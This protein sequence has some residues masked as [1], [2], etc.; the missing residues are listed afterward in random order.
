M[1]SSDPFD[2]ARLAEDYAAYRADKDAEK[3]LAR[4]RDAPTPPPKLFLSLLDYRQP[5]CLR[6]RSG[7]FELWLRATPKPKGGLL[8]CGN[9]DDELPVLYW[10]LRDQAA[11]I[12]Q[13]LVGTH[14]K[15]IEEFVSWF[16]D[17]AHPYAKYFT[18]RYNYT[19]STVYTYG[20]PRFAVWAKLGKEVQDAA[21]SLGIPFPESLRFPAMPDL[22]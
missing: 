9:M 12:F 17:K 3:A 10:L 18:G 16:L 19:S 20:R 1:G 15:A 5:L 11:E 22:E 6:R 14:H 2:V 21:T 13:C 4:Y 7:L 8:W